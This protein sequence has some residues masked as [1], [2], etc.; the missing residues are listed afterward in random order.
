MTAPLTPESATDLALA[1]VMGEPEEKVQP[2]PNEQVAPNAPKPDGTSASDRKRLM[3]KALFGDLFPLANDD[4][5]VAED[6]AA[7]GSW[8]QALWASRRAAVRRHL[9]LVQRNRMMRA[10][11]QWVSS[12]NGSSW[13]DPGRQREAARVVW[14][15]VA[16]ALDQRLQILTDQRPGFS[17]QPATQDP[18]DKKRAMARQLACEFQFDQMDMPAKMREAEYWAQTDGA[19]FVHLFWNVDKGPWDERMGEGA[20]ESEPLGDC[21]CRILRVEQIR[22]SPE[23]TSTVAPSWAVI[24]DIISLTEAVA[25]HGYTGLQG[26][27]GLD[28]DGNQPQATYQGGDGEFNEDWVLSQTVP[29]IGDQLRDTQTVERFTVYLAPQPGIL[30]NGLEVIIVGNQLVLG[31][32]D[33]TFGVIPIVRVPDGSSDPSYLPRPVMEQWLDQQMRVNALL[34]KWVENIRVNAGGRFFTRPNAVTTETFLGGVTSMIEVKGVGALGESIQ[35]FQGFSVGADVK[36]A[37]VME[38]QAFEDISG[39]NAVSRGQVT[40]E[41]GRAIIASR[42]QLERV[43]APPVQALAQAYTHWCRIVLAMMSWGYDLPR[44]LGVVGRSRP[45]LAHAITGN[46][47]DGSDGAARRPGQ[48]RSLR[49]HKCRSNPTRSGSSRVAQPAHRRQP[50]GDPVP[51]GHP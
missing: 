14:N 45:V 29:G 49:R 25:R 30:P 40:G 12:K 6:E 2:T 26:A 27:G 9:H 37:L 44:D 7:W 43:F 36:E 19:A 46:D 21:D 13:T 34:T 39:Y 32:M 10:G 15:L 47:L 41:S 11:N 5:S 50:D 16:P 33:L 23:A 8:V 24:R 3:L 22:V 17:I 31:P 48:W 51:F 20:G 38:K 42:E 1:A 28:M 35:P 4:K 18:S